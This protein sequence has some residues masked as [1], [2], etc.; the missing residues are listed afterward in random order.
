[1]FILTSE[2]IQTIFKSTNQEQLARI[3]NLQAILHKILANFTQIFFYVHNIKHKTLRV[4]QIFARNT[5]DKNNANNIVFFPYYNNTNIILYN[6]NNVTSDSI[7]EN[8]NT[9]FVSSLFGGSTSDSSYNN[10][11]IKY[12]HI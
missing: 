3:N 7:L 9:T 6:D 2:L 10:V 8:N 1:M 4:F 5:C 12:L 11:F